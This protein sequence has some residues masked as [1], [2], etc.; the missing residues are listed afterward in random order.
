MSESTVNTNKKNNYQLYGLKLHS[1]KP[2]KLYSQTI[3]IDLIN[4]N[5]LKTSHKHNP[6]PNSLKTNYPYQPTI[7]QKRYSQSQNPS[8][9][10]D[11]LSF[12][13]NRQ[14]SIVT[15]LI[16]AKT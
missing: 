13:K 9:P 2:Q 7:S 16:K 8:T 11:T 10:N 15:N 12:K 3:L 1:T 6:N 4:L 5:T 14:K